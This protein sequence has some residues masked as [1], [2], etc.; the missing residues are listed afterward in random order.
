MEE[1]EN[2]E[3]PRK[4][5]PRKEEIPRKDVLTRNVKSVIN[6]LCDYFSFSKTLL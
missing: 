4:K 5:P 1:K 2:K 3:I 6:I